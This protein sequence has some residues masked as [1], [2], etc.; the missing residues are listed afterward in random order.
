MMD[1]DLLFVFLLFLIYFVVAEVERRGD[2]NFS[3][4]ALFILFFY[5]KFSFDF[6]FL[7]RYDDIVNYEVGVLLVE[8]E[9]YLMC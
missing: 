7:D 9:W 3:V 8:F 5:L 2:D 6:E 1:N 4:I